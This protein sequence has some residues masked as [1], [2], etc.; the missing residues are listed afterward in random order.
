[1]RYRWDIAMMRYRMRYRICQESRCGSTLSSF[2]LFF[3]CKL[4]RGMWLKLRKPYFHGVVFHSCVFYQC[5]LLSV[6]NDMSTF[7]KWVIIRV[8]SCVLMCTQFV[9]CTP[10][11]FRKVTIFAMNPPKLRNRVTILL[12]FIAAI[13]VETRKVQHWHNLDLEI[14]STVDPPR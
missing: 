14:A 11:S 7:C 5:W 6:H 12:Y 2:G 9:L 4:L 1:M 10:M 3:C 13:K 8:K